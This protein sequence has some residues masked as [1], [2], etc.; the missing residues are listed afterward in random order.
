[1]LVASWGAQPQTNDDQS[2]TSSF[3]CCEAGDGVPNRLLKTETVEPGNAQLCV[4][5]IYTC[6]RYGDKASVSTANCDGATGNALFTSRAGNSAFASQTVTVAAVSG[7]VVPAGAFATSS[8]NALSQ[9]ESRTYD[10]RLGIATGLTGPNG[11]VTN[12]T[13][14]DFGWAVMES[15]ADGTRTV[16]DSSRQGTG[17]PPPTNPAVLSSILQLLLDD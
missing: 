4:T 1:M 3:T 11:L 16:S 13:L 14:D 8:T 9:T 5:T 6:D 17:T 10:P 7:V 12:W 2:R 15:R